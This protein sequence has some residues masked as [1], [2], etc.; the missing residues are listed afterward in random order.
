MVGGQR[1]SGPRPHCVAATHQRAL[2]IGQ[3]ERCRRDP[4]RRPVPRVA[5]ITGKALWAFDLQGGRRIPRWQFLGDELLPGLDV[6]VPAIP[7]GTP[8]GSGCVHAH[9]ATRLRRP[10]P[11]RAPGRRRRPR[12]GCRIHSGSRALLS[13]GPNRRRHKRRQNS[14]SENLTTSPTTPAR[15]GGSTAPKASTCCPGTRCAL[16]AAAVDALGP[17]PGPS[18]HLG[19]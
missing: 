1:T 15:Y 11:D 19:R 14:S 9:P 16:R 17:P 3:H 7:R 18:A 10:D 13:P 2:R 12:A 6:I 8:R 5:A 4:R